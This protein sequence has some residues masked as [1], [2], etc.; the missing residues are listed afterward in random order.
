MP[1]I[2]SRVANYHYIPGYRLKMKSRI[3]CLLGF[4][5]T[6]HAAEDH[7]N[8]NQH[9]HIPDKVSISFAFPERMPI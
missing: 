9:A 1:V 2:G 5:D 8:Q 6:P 4:C 3:P 7:H